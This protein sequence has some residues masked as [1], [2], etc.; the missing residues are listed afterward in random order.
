MRI[1]LENIGML[2][3][4][5]VKIDGLTVIAG[6]NDAGKSTV[7]KVL[8]CI[9]KAISR[10]EEDFQESKINKIED[11]LDRLFFYVR[12]KINIDDEEIFDELKDIFSMDYFL[13]KYNNNQA[14]SMLWYSYL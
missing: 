5:N 2:K 1:E 8:F 12:R 9:I 7:G 10:Y 11:I 6:E 3:K 13:H 14:I 4:A